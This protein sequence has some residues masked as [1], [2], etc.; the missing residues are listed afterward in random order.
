MEN[1]REKAPQ[2][3]AL[4]Q[5]AVS[6]DWHSAADVEPLHVNQVMAQIGIPA[7]NGVPDGIYIALGRIL[8]P[9]AGGPDEESQQKAL[10]DLQGSTMQVSVQGRFIMSRDLLESFIDVLTR[11]A[12]QYD[13]AAA[14]GQSVA[15]HKIREGR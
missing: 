8:P 4:P 15:A 5:I 2:P 6:L 12:R 3:E 13:T 1:A 14:Q 10:A 7:P 9:V 11:A